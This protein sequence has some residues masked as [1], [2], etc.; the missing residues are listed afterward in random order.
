MARTA[1]QVFLGDGRDAERGAGQRGNRLATAKR[2]VGA[3]ERVLARH[4]AGAL[5]PAAGTPARL[6]IRSS[7]D[8]ADLVDAVLEDVKGVVAAGSFVP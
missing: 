6:V 8:G 5:S 2:L 4:T 1:P 7:G 3:Y